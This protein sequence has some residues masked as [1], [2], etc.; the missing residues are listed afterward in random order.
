L[1][2]QFGMKTKLEEVINY[3][4]ENPRKLFLL[5]G[6]GAIVSAF[7]LGVVL[8]KLEEFVGM[9]KEKL[10]YLA[11]APCFFAA[12]SLFCYLRKRKHWR[13]LL[14][15]IAVANTIYC[16]ITFSHLFICSDQ[17]TYLGYFYFITEIIIVMSLVYVEFK[18]SFKKD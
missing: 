10:F 6:M 2:K 18:V 16:L 8:M 5:D 13:K 4:Y 9:P 12:Y 15:I 11:I 14:S 1:L 7:L 17:L 3:F